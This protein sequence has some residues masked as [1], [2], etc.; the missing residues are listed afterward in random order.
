MG[1]DPGASGAIAVLDGEALN[2][3]DVPTKLVQ[4]GKV[5]RGKNK[6]KPRTVK[7]LD[8][9][10]LAEL[11]DGVAGKVD[12]ALIEKVGSMS[13]QGVAGAFAFGQVYGAIRMAVAYSEI[14]YNLVTPQ[15]W[16]GAM[17]CGADK[18]SSLVRCLD[19]FPVEYRHFWFGDRQGILDG[20][21]EAALLALYARKQKMKG[22]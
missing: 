10:K 20:R 1:I 18:R 21:C 2:V 19:L 7:E 3:W 11:I 14:P 16:K 9:E 6:G 17:G 12:Y 8:E 4:R 13:D 22:E 5:S 15:R